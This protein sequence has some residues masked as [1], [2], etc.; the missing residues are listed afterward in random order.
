MRKTIVICACALL[1]LFAGYFTAPIVSMWFL[2]STEPDMFGAFLLSLVDNSV[3]CNCDNQ[4]PSESLKTLTSDLSTL[5]RW[6]TQN[7]SS[8]VLGQEI[9]L[10]DIR[11]A[12]LDQEL[13]HQSQADEDMKQGQ[14]EL[15]A[16]G[17]KDVSPQ[18]LI[19]LTAQLNSEYKPIDQK[20]KTVAVTH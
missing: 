3:V 8:H 9:G 7:Q 1:G 2:Q 15:T 19:A 18:H 5:Q 4:P 6:R 17:W 13:G 10:V 14:R 16:L 11:L 12:R 20:N